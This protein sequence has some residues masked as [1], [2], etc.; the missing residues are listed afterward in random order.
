MVIRALPDLEGS[1]RSGAI[2]ARCHRAGLGIPPR[3]ELQRRPWSEDVAAEAVE[4]CLARFKEKVLPAGEWDPERGT[5]EDFFTSCCLPDVANQ[6]RWH[7]RR[8]LPDGIELD[9]LDEAEQA[10]VLAQTLNPPRDPAHLAELRDELTRVTAWMSS[11]DKKTFIMINEGWSPAEIAGL[12]GISRN[13]LD[14]RISRA[15]KAAR[16]RRTP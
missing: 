3:P 11:D 4:Q 2:V 7:L 9:G 14:A 8:L 6:W 12:L 16:A 10:S 1:I 5:L 15:R 13:T